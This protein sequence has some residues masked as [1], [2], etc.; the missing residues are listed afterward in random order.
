MLEIS[1][2]S[3]CAAPIWNLPFASEAVEECFCLFVMVAPATGL[4]TESITVPE[5]VLGVCAFTPAASSIKLKKM[6]V[7][8]ILSN[9]IIIAGCLK[10]FPVRF[11]NELVLQLRMY[12]VRYL[13]NPACSN[14][15][16]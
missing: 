15:V 8:H 4:P 7:G 16:T 3:P 10:Q 1:S 12:V 9:R 6:N 14:R 13:A 5:I 11:K 2:S